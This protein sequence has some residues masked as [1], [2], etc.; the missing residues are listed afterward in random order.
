MLSG[1]ST[2]WRHGARADVA[3]GAAADALADLE[4]GVGL[5]LHPV[6][7]VAETQP[8]GAVILGLDHEVEGERS[9]LEERLA[10]VPVPHLGLV[11]A[12]RPAAERAAGAA[13]SCTSRSSTAA[14]TA[15]PAASSRSAALTVPSS[16]APAEKVTSG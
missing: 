6:G 8:G 4:H 16:A 1:P 10:H 12:G 5:G 15:R 9:A 13:M 3:L 14:R 11:G 2:M 7:P